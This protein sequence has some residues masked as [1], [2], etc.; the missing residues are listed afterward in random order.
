MVYYCD[1]VLILNFF[2]D[3]IFDIFMKPSHKDI[4]VLSVHEAIDMLVGLGALP[5]TADPVFRKDAYAYLRKRAIDRDRFRRTL[6]YLIDRGYVRDAVKGKQ[7][8]LEVTDRGQSVARPQAAFLLRTPAR[9]DRRWRIV[10]FDIPA[11]Y[12]NTRHYFPEKLKQWGFLPMQRSVYVYPFDCHQQI[13]DLIELYKLDGTVQYMIAEIIEGEETIINTFLD[14]G[15]LKR[16]HF[17]RAKS[18]PK[19]KSK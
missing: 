4:I 1:I 11:R 15:V 18:V 2:V 12:T 13:R 9:W 3:T 16:T 5:Y 7:R 6:R 10:I 8:Y 14:N 17:S 19:K